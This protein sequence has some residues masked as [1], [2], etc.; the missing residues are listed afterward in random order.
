V[1]PVRGVVM[2]LRLPVLNTFQSMVHDLQIH[3]NACLTMI[4][5]SRSYIFWTIQWIAFHFWLTLFVFVDKPVSFVNHAIWF[6]MINLCASMTFCPCSW[7]PYFFVTVCISNLC[8][9]SNAPSW[10][11]MCMSKRS[12]KLVTTSALMAIQE[13]AKVWRMERCNF[14]GYLEVSLIMIIAMFLPFNW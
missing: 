6:L 5:R 1:L 14:I 13:K 10:A 3:N 11:M 8:C 12:P 4:V 9:A 2:L 7:L